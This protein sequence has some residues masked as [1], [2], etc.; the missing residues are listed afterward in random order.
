MADDADFDVIACGETV[1]QMWKQLANQIALAIP[2]MV[3]AGK[4]EEAIRWAACAEACF[5]KAT[6][7]SNTHDIKDVVTLL[8]KEGLTE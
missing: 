6:G 4:P 7:E 5:W 2:D 8:P 3:I 1:S